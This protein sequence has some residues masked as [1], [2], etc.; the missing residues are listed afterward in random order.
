MNVLFGTGRF[1]RQSVS[2]KRKKSYFP[3]KP[4]SAWMFSSWSERGLSVRSAGQEYCR[5]TTRESRWGWTALVGCVWGVFCLWTCIRM[6]EWMG[7]GELMRKRNERWEVE[8]LKEKEHKWVYTVVGT[9]LGQN[10]LEFVIVGKNLSI[11]WGQMAGVW[12]SAYLV[13]QESDGWAFP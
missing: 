13:C 10:E 4:S 8:R 12:W 2:H 7:D 3:W 9:A 11:R 5:F 1:R 6:L